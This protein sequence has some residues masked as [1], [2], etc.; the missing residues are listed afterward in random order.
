MALA[1]LVDSTVRLVYDAGL[2]ENGDVVL[3]AKS[4]NNINLNATAD[5]IFAAAQ[6]I[7]SLTS[8]PLLAIERSDK[9]EIYE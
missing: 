3:K 6:A 4:Y 8:L 9:T 1:N 5:Q 7:A 2:D